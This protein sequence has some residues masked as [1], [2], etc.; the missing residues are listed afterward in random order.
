MPTFIYDA[1]TSDVSISMTSNTPS[2]ALEWALAY[3]RLCYESGRIDRAT[4]IGVLIGRSTDEGHSIDIRAMYGDT[5]Q[6]YFGYVFP[7]D[8]FQ[9]IKNIV[10]Q[11]SEDIENYGHD[12]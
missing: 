7:N 10:N 1:T 8:D 11:L 4:V 5:E 2:E 6:R 9:S 3:F 12:L